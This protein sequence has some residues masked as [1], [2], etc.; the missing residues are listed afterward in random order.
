MTAEGASYLSPDE[1]QELIWLMKDAQDRR[2]PPPEERRLREV[3]S[4]RDPL[5]R[6]MP[7]DELVDFGLVVLGGY[8]MLKLMN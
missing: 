3:L 4:L 2:L 7:W 6:D 8:F 1:W 5:A